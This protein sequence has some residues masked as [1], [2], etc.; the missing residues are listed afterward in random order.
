MTT[1]VQAVNRWQVG[2]VRITRIIELESLFPSDL[3]MVGT[4]AEQIKTV[5]WLHPH[6]ADAD[7]MLRYSV[8]AFV[9]ESQGRR[10]IVDT[11]VGK[12]KA[13]S[14]EWNQ[15]NVLNVPFLEHLSDAGFSPE[16]IDFVLCTHLHMDHV[17]WNTRLVGTSWVPTFPRSRYLF[18][19]VEW[20]HWSNEAHGLGDIPQFVADFASLDTAIRDSVAPVVSA[21][22][23][24]FVEMNHRITDEVSLFPTPGH[25]PGHVS[26]AIRSR[27]REAVITG[28]VILHPLQIADPEVCSTFD[29]DRMVTMKTRQEFIHARADRDV[30]VL[31]THFTTPSGGKI[32]AQ[33]KG[34]RFVPVV[35]GG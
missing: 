35:D 4:T 25:T 3:M 12:D 32:V 15:L 31:G 2:D 30:L 1:T 10:I 11:C 28:D 7:G 34:W 27:G 16:A 20:E 5:D 33:G 13:R 26:V 23:H 8:H 18:G 14:G 29:T 9:V 17:G 24:D 6:Y 21:G 22:L 19:R